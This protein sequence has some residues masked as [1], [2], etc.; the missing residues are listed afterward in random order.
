[1]IGDLRWVIGG[2]R[3]EFIGY[4]ATEVDNTLDEASQTEDR[5]LP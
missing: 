3:S 2:C 5:E 1:M 4:L